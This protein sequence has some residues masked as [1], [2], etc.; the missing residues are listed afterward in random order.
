MN[1]A[2][3]LA[4][5]LAVVLATSIAAAA[6]PEAQ[7]SG[8]ALLSIR[9]RAALVYKIVQKRLDTLLPRM[10]RET[11][12]DMWV[13]SC[14][15]DNLDPI[16]ETMMPYENWCPITQIL[17]LYDRGA[18]KGIERINV[19]RT[20]T[21]S[22]FT[23][24]WDAAA[25]DA[26]KGEGQWEAFG[27]IV[28]ERNPKKIALN[29]GEIQWS[30]GA[31]TTV[32]KKRIIEALGPGLA[33]RI[34]SAEPLATLWGETLLPEE[35]EIQERAAAISHAII[36]EMFSN[37]TITVG[38]TT[39]EDLRWFYWQRASDLGLKVSFSP[40][41]SIRVR[42]PETLAAYGKDDKAIRP[43]DYLHCD[44]G[45]KYMRWNSDNQEVAYV[46]KPGENDA[47]EG[48]RKLMAETNRL[49]DVFCGEFETGLTGNELLGRILAKAK[50]MGIPGPKIYSHSLG[51]FLHEPGPLIGLPW[52]QVNNVGRGDVKLVPW[53]VFTVE[54]SV[55]GPMPE[56]S[57]AELRVPLEQDIVFNGEKAIFLDGRQTA[58]HLIR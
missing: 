30:A 12:I 9:D 48:M 27:R 24:G 17:V 6:V 5:V 25:F 44:V 26:K 55:T 2:R 14:N 35:V 34:V 36:A 58:F 3:T 41:V 7:K 10:M 18:D 13:L 51:L 19:A 45:V 8:P 31:L 42:S 54:L 46:L 22:L 37:R 38:Q 50:A 11:G 39:A 4:P 47:P 32:L 20:D 21:Q 53:S 16:F 56:W 33:S 29:E 40:F 23:N 57:L 52:E 15:E 43:G 49:Q 28:R 1:K